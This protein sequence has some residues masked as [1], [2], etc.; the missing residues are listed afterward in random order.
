MGFFWI[1]VT[2]LIGAAFVPGRLWTFLISFC[3]IEA[4][5]QHNKALRQA[6]GKEKD[7]I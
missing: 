2:G 7:V 3:A 1:F 6:R 5:L 4:M